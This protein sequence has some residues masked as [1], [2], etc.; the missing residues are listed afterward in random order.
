MN[1]VKCFFRGITLCSPAQVQRHRRAMHLRR[2][3]PVGE[4][5]DHP[6]E[7]F[8]EILEIIDELMKNFC[9]VIDD[10]DIHW[11]KVA[12]I[13]PLVEKFRKERELLLK[14]GYTRT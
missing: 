1:A 6:K 10:E 8:D 9:F 14:E 11:L 3:A 13:H 4:V 12:Q 5:S 2:R 7:V